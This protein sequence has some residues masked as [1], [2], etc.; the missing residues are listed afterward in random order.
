[1]SFYA[2]TKL[3]LDGIIYIVKDNFDFVNYILTQYHRNNIGVYSFKI[4]LFSPI[5]KQKG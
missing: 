4:A 3:R 1:M 2:K 5:Y